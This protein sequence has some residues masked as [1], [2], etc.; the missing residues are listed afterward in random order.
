MNAQIEQRP[1]RQPVP[2]LNYLPTPSG[3]RRALRIARVRVPLT[4][5]VSPWA[6]LY[7]LPDGRR[8]WC[9][10]LRDATGVG[11]RCVGSEHLLRYAEESGLRLLHRQL[12]DA[13]ELARRTRG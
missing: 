4:L 8:I 7:V 13:L 1:E 12:L 10:R 3:L 5:T 2:E 6:T 9:V 11:T